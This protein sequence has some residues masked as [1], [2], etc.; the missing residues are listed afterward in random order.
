MEKTTQKALKLLV[1]YN[2]VKDITRFNFDMV[3]ALRE[4]ENGLSVVSVSVGQYGMNGALLQGNK[5]KTDYVI[6]ARSSSLFQLV[7]SHRQG[8]K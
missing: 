7:W 1:A 2:D 3:N 5:T 6:T 8:K 4:E